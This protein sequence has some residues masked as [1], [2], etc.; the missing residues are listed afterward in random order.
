VENEIICLDTSVLIDYYR[1]KKKENSFFF[2]LTKKYSL[3]AVSVISEYE[4][5]IGSNT[6]QDI[7]WDDFFKMLSVF[8][9][10]SEIDKLAVKTA[11]QLK[12]KGIKLDVPD[13]FIGATALFNDIKLATLNKK[14]FEYFDKLILLTPAEITI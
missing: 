2:T 13:L 14:H 4:I 1:K 7:Y 8:P 11:K 6:D 9:F 5:Y 12:K 3:F 10:T